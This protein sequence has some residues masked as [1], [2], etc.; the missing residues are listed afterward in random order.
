[1]IGLSVGILSS[2]Q[3]SARVRVAWRAMNGMSLTFDE[4]V[5]AA[6]HRQLQRHRR[7]GVGA[8]DGRQQRRREPHA[9]VVGVDPV[10]GE[11]AERHGGDA[12][13]RAHGEGQRRDVADDEAG[14]ELAQRA[15]LAGRARHQVA[16][17][18]RGAADAV[19]LVERQ[20]VH[21]HDAGV[22]FEGAVRHLA[23]DREVEEPARRRRADADPHFGTFGQDGVDD[24]D[25]ARRVPE[26]VAGNIKDDRLC[27]IKRLFSSNATFTTCSRVSTGTKVM[28][29]RS[30]SG[31]S[32]KSGSLSAGS[33]KVLHPEPPGRQRLLPNAADGQH[34]P[35]ER[36]FARHRH[37]LLHRL[38]A[39]RRQNR[40]RY[41]DAG[42]RT[43]LRDG[44]GRD[45]NV[46]VVLGEE[47][48][49]N[50]ECLGA[51]PDVAQGRPSR[52]LHHVPQLARKNDVLVSARKQGDFDE[53][54][55]AAHFGPGHPGHHPRCRGPEGHFLLE[56]GRPQVIVH[57]G[58]VHDGL[59]AAAGRRPGGWRCGRPASGRWCRAA[60][61]GSGPRLR[62]CTR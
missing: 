12:G 38:V 59:G 46:E 21:L 7:L 42:G 45:V 62:G 44:A 37:A 47:F 15:R 18:R 41:G 29:R 32:N 28:S 22:A 30:S 5:E 16:V 43:V 60:V 1:M 3:T 54:D 10:P 57:F 2:L 36:D 23:L 33:T 48:G 20:P 58:A 52:L 39:R 11:V 13:R 17:E 49:R 6:R 25:R 24:L 51:R 4:V 9:R 26:S 50:P 53:Q 40:R 35:A 19:G 55:V 27:Q 8:A 61:R 56:P 34:Q 14:A 31:S